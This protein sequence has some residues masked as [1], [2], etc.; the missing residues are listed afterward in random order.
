M[1]PLEAITGPNSGI[2]KYQIKKI[3]LW[4]IRPFSRKSACLDLPHGGANGDIIFSGQFSWSK[5]K[6]LKI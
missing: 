5:F 2:V 6:V 1:Q 4:K 3:F